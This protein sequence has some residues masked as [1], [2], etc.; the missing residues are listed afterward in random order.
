V[1]SI[2]TD[3]VP[4]R[5]GCVAQAGKQWGV[6]LL[7]CGD[8]SLYAGATNDLAARVARHQRGLGSRY[9]RSRLPVELAYWEPCADRSA[10]LKREV[11]LKRLSRSAKL[12]LIAR[13]APAETRLAAAS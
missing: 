7:R 5:L 8:D 13:Q 6:Y 11:A 10:A 3:G 2:E 9:T 4:D 12:A 1:A